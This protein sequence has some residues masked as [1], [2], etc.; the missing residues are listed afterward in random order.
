[1]F[2]IFASIGKLMMKVT[3]TNFSEGKWMLSKGSLVI[4]VRVMKA[5]TRYVMHAKY[6]EKRLMPSKTDVIES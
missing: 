4:I 5:N 3:P 1:M 6:K 2:L